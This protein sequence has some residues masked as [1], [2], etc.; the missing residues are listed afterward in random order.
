M[1]VVLDEDE[2]AQRLER[3]VRRDFFPNLTRLERALSARRRGVPEL[4][5]GREDEEDEDADLGLDEFC[6]RFTGEDNAAFTR[7]QR[8]EAEARQARAERFGMLPPASAP[9]GAL[10]IAGGGARG[11]GRADAAGGGPPKSVNARATRF[12]SPGG[13]GGGRSG[14]RRGGASTPASSS[15]ACDSSDDDSRI[16]SGPFLAWGGDGAPRRGDGGVAG[17]GPQRV[18]RRD[19]SVQ[20]ASRKELL[21]R[22]LAQAQATPSSPSAAGTPGG[23][24]PRSTSIFAS[25]SPARSPFATPLRSPSAASHMRSP[26]GKRGATPLGAA[27]AE[28]A[29]RML[30]SKRSR[31]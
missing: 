14:G 2:W 10:A 4:A 3:I 28:L 23:R 25:P 7:L 31:R 27:A 29:D 16:N 20:E 9:R 17:D 15:L 13:G 6:A 22:R 11:R 21:T 26:A 18:R 1:K 5:D 30:A 8:R 24:A 19:F 12:V